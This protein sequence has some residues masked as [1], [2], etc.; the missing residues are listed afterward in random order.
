VIFGL[1]RLL[2]IERTERREDWRAN[3]LSFGS[4]PRAEGLVCKTVGSVRLI[5]DVQAFRNAFPKR[6]TAPSSLKR[7]RLSAFDISS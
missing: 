3:G 5:A 4:T 7:T 1:E 6:I 2:L